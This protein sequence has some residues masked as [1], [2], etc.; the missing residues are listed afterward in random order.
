[1]ILRMQIKPTGSCLGADILDIDLS[2]ELSDQQFSDIVEAWHS[3]SIL[4]FRKQELSDDEFVNFSRRFGSLDLAPTGRGGKPF[5]ASRPEIAIISN[6]IVNGKKAGSLG[7]SELVWHQDMSYVNLPP[8][9]SVLYGIEIPK[10]S[11]DTSFYSAY[12]AYSA[13]PPKL[14]TKINGLTCKHD[15]TRNSAGELRVGY[16]ETYHNKERPGA[17]HPLVILHPNTKRKALFLGR[18]PNAWIYGFSSEA[19]DALL[20]ELWDHINSHNFTWTQNWE[21][22]DLVIWD[23]RCTFHRRE[24]LDPSQNRLMHRLQIADDYPPTAPS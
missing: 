7:N 15:A 10:S 12:E 21:E 6:I 8:K 17:I 13:L 4:R 14:K 20:D 19:S 2:Q 18:R 5:N 24:K 22:G 16:A 3:F 1:M 23:N 9:A 11:G